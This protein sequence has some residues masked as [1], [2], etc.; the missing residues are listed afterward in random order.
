MS[1]KKNKGSKKKKNLID[2]D[3]TNKAFEFSY[4]NSKYVNILEQIVV[5]TS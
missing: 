3:F 1:W 5:L 2:I 4:R